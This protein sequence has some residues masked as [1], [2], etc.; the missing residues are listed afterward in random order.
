MTL[1]DVIN[2]RM[3]ENDAEA[4]TIG[5]YLKQLLLKLW[6]EKEGF[7]SKRPF[8]NSGWDYDL[9]ATLIKCGAVKGKLDDYGFVEEID[10]DQAD[11]MII[12]I[13]NTI[14]D[15]ASADVTVEG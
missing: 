14:F 7:S 2:T 1:I 15:Q 11:K 9:Y 8:G 3:E 5:D 10:C 13:I 6:N 12:S 4:K